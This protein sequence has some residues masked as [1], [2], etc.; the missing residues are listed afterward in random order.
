M[1]LQAVYSLIIIT[2]LIFSLFNISSEQCVLGGNCPLNQGECVNNACNCLSGFYTLLDPQL[3]PEQQ[4][5]CNYEQINVYAPVIL[6][7]FLPSF[8]H[9]YTGKYYLGIAKLILLFIYLTSSYYLYDKLE[10][11]IYIRYIMEKFGPAL[12]SLI[13]LK[14]AEE[15]EEEN[16]GKEEDTLADLI[17]SKFKS[18]KTK[19]TINMKEGLNR[20]ETSQMTQVHDKLEGDDKVEEKEKEEKK[21]DIVEQIY[22]E[23]NKPTKN[24]KDDDDNKSDK[25]KP[26]LDKD[27]DQNDS[28]TGSKDSRSKDD[29]KVENI[30]IKNIFELSSLC[31]S[32]MYFADLLFFKFKVY[33]DGYG[34][35]FIE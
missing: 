19:T 12:L 18:G 27:D 24:D 20:G 17:K 7:L 3:P 23:D 11:P 4:T 6:E 2:I 16:K 22:D 30:P 26:L 13:G 9:F 21:Y 1:Y 34:I 14:L 29:T 25:E 15:E 8:G 32:I 35:P 5:Y 31:F 10:M 28:E 33:S